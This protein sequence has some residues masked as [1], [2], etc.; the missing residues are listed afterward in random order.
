MDL[1]L[2]RDKFIEDS[3]LL[4]DYFEDKPV[5]QIDFYDMLEF[6]EIN[7]KLFKRLYLYNY[8]SFTSD[9][10]FYM[11]EKCNYLGNCKLYDLLEFCKKSHPEISDNFSPGVKR[12]YELTIAVLD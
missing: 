1:Y 10:L 4:T 11:I 3:T 5:S 9:E 7:V 6:F 12:E 2:I 8:Y